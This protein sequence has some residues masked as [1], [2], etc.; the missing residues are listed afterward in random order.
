MKALHL[1]T[2]WEGCIHGIKSFDNSGLAIGCNVTIRGLKKD[3]ELNGQKATIIQRIKMK[4]NADKVVEAYE[5]KVVDTE[6][7]KKLHRI[8]SFTE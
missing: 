5:V 7:H 8:K 2:S 6:E 4:D 1:L 3:T